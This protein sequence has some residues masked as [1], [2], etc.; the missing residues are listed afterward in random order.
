MVRG[1]QKEAEAILTVFG[2]VFLSLSRSMVSELATWMGTCLLKIPLLGLGYH[3]VFR[4]SYLDP[5]AL[6]KADL[7]MAGF[8]III[9]EED[10]EWEEL[11]FHHLVD[12]TYLLCNFKNFYVV[13]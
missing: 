6:T 12:I 8:Q 1:R 2:A 13:I 4:I 5:K 3:K 7:I 10:Y 9:A 11:L